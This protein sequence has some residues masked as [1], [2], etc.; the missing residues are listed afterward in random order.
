MRRLGLKSCSSRGLNGCNGR[1]VFVTAARDVF[2]V[3]SSGPDRS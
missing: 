1:F 2:G 3:C